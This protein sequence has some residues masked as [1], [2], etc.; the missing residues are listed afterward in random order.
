MRRRCSPFAITRHLNLAGPVAH[1]FPMSQC[2]RLLRRYY[3]FSFWLGYGA[4]GTS[5]VRCLPEGSA[6]G[7]VALAFVA[8][9]EP[10]MGW[11]L[12]LATMSLYVYDMQSFDVSI[13]SIPP[14]VIP[15]LLDVD[16]STSAREEVYGL[17]QHSRSS[18]SSS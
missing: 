5:T 6:S 11:L 4:S 10:E 8:S 15:T 13:S 17:S 1:R 2:Y 14:P 16:F 9:G 18:H 12:S 3:F 7:P